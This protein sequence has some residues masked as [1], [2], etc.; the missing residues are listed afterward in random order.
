MEVIDFTLKFHF[1]H[2][3]QVEINLFSWHM[4]PLVINQG[5]P[6]RE[7]D[8]VVISRKEM[9]AAGLMWPTYNYANQSV[10][11]RMHLIPVSIKVLCF[12][13]RYRI[14]QKSAYGKKFRRGHG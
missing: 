14:W 7:K 13:V 2:R 11:H 1:T 6:V 3:V 9:N 10:F 4:I 8:P 5:L 12:V